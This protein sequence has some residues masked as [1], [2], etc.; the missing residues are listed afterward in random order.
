MAQ[1]PVDNMIG[2]RFA[3]A[4]PGFSLTQDNSR[5]PWGKPSKFADPEEALEDTLKRTLNPKNKQEL[6]KLLMVGVSI[7][8]IVE[9]IIFQGFQEGLFTPDV[10]MLMKPSLALVIADECEEAGIPYRMFENSDIE[11]E[12][13][14]DDETFL[15]MMKD[16]NPQMFSFIQEKLNAAFRAGTQP[17]EPEPE[18]GFLSAKGGDKE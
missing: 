8:V 2:D 11:T 4:P 16:N 9:G 14:M 10:G 15:R 5:W 6:F 1:P 17:R 3:I 18:R 13:E 7:E 12:G